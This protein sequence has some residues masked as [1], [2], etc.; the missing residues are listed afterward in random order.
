MFSTALLLGFGSSLHCIGMCGPLAMAL[1][2]AVDDRLAMIKG[3][4]IYHFG[5]LL[6]YSGLGLLFGIV[7]KGLVLDG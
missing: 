5:R 4:L 6:T 2:L 7:G 1:P 3:L